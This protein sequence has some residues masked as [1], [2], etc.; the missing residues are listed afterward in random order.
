M[1]PELYLLIVKLGNPQTDSFPKTT[2]LMRAICYCVKYALKARMPLSINLSFG[3]TY[4][5]HMGTALLERFMD[6]ASEIGRTV[7]SVGSGNEGA[8]NGHVAG[9][10]HDYSSPNTL[11]VVERKIE[12]MV[13]NY[14]RGLQVQLWKQYGDDY[15]IEITAPGRSVFS[16]SGK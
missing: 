7:I 11:T 12:L 15:E 4:G 10:V 1:A 13:D 6:N 3:N 2:E 8:S 16:F 9:N 14:E 5:N